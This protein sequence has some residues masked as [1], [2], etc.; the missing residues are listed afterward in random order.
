MEAHQRDGHVIICADVFE[1]LEGVPGASVDLVFADPPYN[2]G[3][4]YHNSRDRWES[5]DAY[6]GWC[7]RWIDACLG[8]LKPD[9]AMYLMTSTQSMP[10][11]D[12]HLRQR[13]TVLSRIVWCYDSSGVQAKRRFGS[14]YEPILYCV[15]DERNYC[16][17]GDDIRVATETGARR[18]LV[19]KRKAVP[20]PYSH[21]KLPGNVWE[22]PRVRYLMA[23][24]QAHPTQKPEALLERIIRASTD[25]GDT[26]LD[27]FAGSFTASAVACRLGRKSIGID[28]SPEYCAIGRR[29]IFG[30]AQ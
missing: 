30:E 6:L 22:F 20:A 3:K 13:T 9:G 12:I 15:M 14:L 10:F 8:K 23:E 2:I 19:D 5:E 27:P 29:R 7:R 4:I 26:V 18:R 21:S 16:F 24:Y 11:L 17:N 28:I 25:S 1:G